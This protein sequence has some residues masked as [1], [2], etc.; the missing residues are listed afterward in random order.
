ML[1]QDD[2]VS[3]K[4]RELRMEFLSERSLAT[5]LPCRTSWAAYIE[6]VKLVGRTPNAI[7]EEKNISFQP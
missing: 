4:H 1:T 6:K 7:C 2:G 3:R 5:K